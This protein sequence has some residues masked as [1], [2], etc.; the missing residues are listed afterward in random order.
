MPT[1]YNNDK[2]VSYSGTI[3][4]APDKSISPGGTISTS[5][6]MV[7]G[8]GTTFLSSLGGTSLYNGVGNPST[9]TPHRYIFVPSFGEVRKVKDVISDTQCVL[10][11][12]FTGNIIAPVTFQYVVESRTKQM[13][14]LVTSGT[15]SVDNVSWAADTFSGWDNTEPINFNTVDPVVIDATSG[16]LVLTKYTAA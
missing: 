15:V 8:T 13:S 1:N 6:Q 3:D 14:F 7:Y 10:E 11:S 16:A 12:S 5:G 2:V 4:T 9:A